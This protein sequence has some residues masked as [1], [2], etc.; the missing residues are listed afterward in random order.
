MFMS[1]SKPYFEVIDNL[2]SLKT[3]KYKD[4]TIVLR[5]A[6][7]Y[8]CKLKAI[9]EVLSELY[10]NACNKYKTKSDMA[11]AKDL[12]YG[13]SFKCSKLTCGD[14]LVFSIKY[15]FTNP[16][17]LNDVDIE[18]YIDF[19]DETLHHPYISEN[20]FSEAKEVTIDYLKRKLD[21]PSSYADNE[22]NKIVTLD[23]ATYDIQLNDYI[24][25]IED[26]TIN[27][28]NDFLLELFNTSIEIYLVGDF[29]EKLFNYL[30]GIKSKQDFSISAHLLNLKRKDD[31]VVK[32]E[33]GQ[34]TLIVSYIS[35][36]STKSEDYFAY[37]LGCHLLGGSASSLLFS[38]VREKQ[39]LCY[40]INIRIDKYFGLLKIITNID[41]KNKDKVIASIK[42]QVNRIV[43]KDYD[44]ELLDKVKSTIYN[45]YSL[46]EDDASLYI[47]LDY[48]CIM[49][50]RT[51]D[52]DAKRELIRR[53]SIDDISNTFKK[54]NEY[55]VFMLEG[56]KN[57]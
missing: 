18:N 55:L 46:F 42:E 14:L 17:F 45:D 7:K 57:G 8:S 2:H 28:I 31:V 30:K 53:V 41:S 38:E 54:L 3:N 1:N 32:K 25:E 24:H 20:L 43:N 36:F 52:L 40:A 39:S 10:Q 37:L 35:P 12:L 4:I 26:L 27:D 22:F 6:Y 13:I 5:F 15:S 19:I 29:D 21:K 50:N 48:E 51:T 33:I 49:D 34:S 47:S 23:D 56:I 44:P 16:K 11:K 9:L